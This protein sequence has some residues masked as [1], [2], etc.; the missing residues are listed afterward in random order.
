VG[1]GTNSPNPSSILDLSSSN[2]GLLP[3]RMTFAQRNSI[4]TPAPGLLVWCTDCGASGELCVFNGVSWKS[5]TMT[6]TIE[7]NPCLNTNVVVNTTPTNN[8]SCQTPNGSI[9]VA[10][11]G[12]TG[13]TY[14]ING[15]NFQSNNN[16]NSLNAGNYTITVKDI[17]GCT[18]TASATI[19]ST[20]PAI[21]VNA[22]AGNITSCSTP[23]GSISASASGSSGF[24]Y[25]ING[26]SFQ[27]NGNFTAL[28]AGNYTITAKDANGCTGSKPVSITTASNGPLFTSVKNIIN[29]RCGGCHTVGGS[30][31][32]VSFATDCGIVN[33][34]LRIQARAVTQGTMPPSGFI[35]L[36]ER[37]AINDWINA[38]GQFNQ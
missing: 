32:G 16:F 37:A 17:N 33:K 9:N 27:T 10:A 26:T 21:T 22:T 12:S 18:G 5:A 38:G 29:A 31:G 3:P 8:T 14:S 25:S 30:S 34:A 1:I 15:G 36:N 6:E 28:S 35:P 23:N 7:P 19:T 20:S 4:A 13:F 2:K 11:S 24:T